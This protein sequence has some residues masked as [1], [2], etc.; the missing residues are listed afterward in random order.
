MAG[1]ITVAQVAEQQAA[2]SEAITQQ[3][4]AI[5]QIAEAVAG[6]T[7]LLTQGQPATSAA[8]A[9]KVAE[10]PVVTPRDAMKSHVES[11]NLRLA[12]GGAL[13]GSAEVAKAIVRVLQNGTPG[14]TEVVS[15][16]GEVKSL[17]SRKVTHVAVVLLAPGHFTTQYV[18]TPEA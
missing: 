18:Y 8:V 6:L 3:G 13:Q 10:T 4:T 9:E 12:K 17:D 14:H 15:V 16:T 11:K 5:T 2:Q 7:A 1:R